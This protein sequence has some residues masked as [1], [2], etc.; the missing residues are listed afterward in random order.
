MY[1]AVT[2]INDGIYKVLR[3]FIMLL[4]AALSTLVFMAVVARFVKISMPWSEEL[5]IYVFSWLTYFGAAVVLRNN[6]HIGVSAFLN[7]VKNETVKKILIIVGQLVI[8]AFACTAVRLSSGMV[9]QFYIN[10]LRSTN[11]TGLKMAFVFLQV[12]VSNAVYV[13]FMAEKILATV[14]GKGEDK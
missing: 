5:A 10:D 2:R 11:M 1:Q 12:P 9:R 4:L 3:I 13:L 7:A 8:L 14:L 6:G